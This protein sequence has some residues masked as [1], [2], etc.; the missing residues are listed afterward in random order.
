MRA[1]SGPTLTAIA[2]KVVALAQLVKLDLPIP[3]YVN[4]SS[5]DITWIGNTYIGAPGVGR[6]EPIDD[7][8]GDIKPIRFEMPAIIDADLA[9]A[10]AG[11]P[12]GAPATIYTAVFDSA[13][14]QVI[15]TV[16]EYAGRLDTFSIAEDGES[17]VIQATA[18]HIGVDLLRPGNLLYSNQDQQRIHPGDRSMEY[19]VDQSEQQIVFPAASYFRK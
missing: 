9:E 3:W 13:T 8:P 14:A 10:L 1:L 17:S 7:T 2:D 12:Q 11:Q 19:V 18:E 15:E 6:I 16:V 4:T 5:W